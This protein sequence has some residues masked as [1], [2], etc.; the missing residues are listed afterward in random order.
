MSKRQIS[1][2][3]MRE[4]QLGILD[5]IHAFCVSKGLRYSL[6]GGTLLGAVRH[7]GYIPWDD[8]IDIM[9]PRPDYERLLS[10]FPTAEHHLA[11][12]NYRNDP[13]YFQAFTK[14]YD[15]RTEFKEY[16]T[17]D[18]QTRLLYDTGVN[19]EV[20][21]VDGLPAPD[22]MAAYMA[23]LSDCMAHLANSTCYRYF[24]TLQRLKY[25]LKLLIYRH[26][27]IRLKKSRRQ[28]MRDLDGYLK[29]YAFD[30]SDY[31]GAITGIYGLK[32]HMDADIFRHYVTLPFE[33]REYMAIADYNAYLS[34]HYGD[35]MQLPPVEKRKT[36][37][38]FRAYWK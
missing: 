21:P 1:T 30:S 16:G 7:Q 20:F 36:D 8:D 6:G 25:R 31:A 28:S 17:L 23:G 29:Q 35:Y 3:E 19:V 9:L 11:I 10:E 32:E 37:H 27:N 24:N 18:G 34:K 15:T 12:H 2:P 4:I 14:I 33:G 38:I 26:I 13:S 22:G 5:K